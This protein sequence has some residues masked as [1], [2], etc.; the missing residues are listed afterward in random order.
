MAASSRSRAGWS[1]F[2]GVATGILNGGD[3]FL[4]GLSRPV[5]LVDGE[6]QLAQKCV[7]LPDKVR[8]ACLVRK[9]RRPLGCCQ[10]LVPRF[11]IAALP[12]QVG[13]AA[14]GSRLPSLVSG[15]DADGKRTPEFV[16]RQIELSVLQM[17]TAQ[18]LQTGGEARPVANFVGGSDAPGHPLDGFVPLATLR[19]HVGDVVAQVNLPTGVIPGDGES[20]LPVVQCPV[21]QPLSQ[22]NAAG[23]VQGVDG[24]FLAMDLPINSQRTP[25]LRQRLP[26]APQLQADDPFSRQGSGELVLIVRGLEDALGLRAF[27]QRR[28]VVA[29]RA[30]DGAEQV[31]RESGIYHV[32]ASEHQVAGVFAQR[33]R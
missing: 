17:E 32:A 27:F 9:H 13:Q 23:S 10:G 3:A 22:E 20:L 5:W 15:F 6:Q 7:A 31:Q 21:S 1:G 19:I 16:F 26:E 18:F 4:E 2:C 30:V 33:G 8:L 25:G 12:Q 29:T 24:P 28:L 11:L 14:Q